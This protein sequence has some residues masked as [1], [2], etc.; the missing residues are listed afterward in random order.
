MQKKG[1]GQNLGGINFIGRIVG[2]LKLL[3]LLMRDYA[4][5]RY[6]DVAWGALIAVLLAI[7]YVLSPFD[8]IPDWIPGWGQLD[9]AAIIGI[10]LYVIE[11]DLQ[12]YKAWKGRDDSDNQ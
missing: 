6:R 5:G 4:T 8:F 12:K 7:F 2:D 11:K 1:S 10:C 3:A 9:D